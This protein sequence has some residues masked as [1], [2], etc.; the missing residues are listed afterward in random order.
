MVE[1]TQAVPIH[2]ENVPDIWGRSILAIGKRLKT[3]PGAGHQI[4]DSARR[5]DLTRSG[6]LGQTVSNMNRRAGHVGVADVYF[7]DLNANAHA[8]AIWSVQDRAGKAYGARGSVE[9]RIDALGAADDSALKAWEGLCRNGGER[10]WLHLVT[11]QMDDGGQDRLPLCGWNFLF[12]CH[13][14]L[15]DGGKEGILI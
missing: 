14:E 9:D 10:R 3:N 8:V 4:S 7:A 2:D 13:E 11:C 12:G 5:Q 15:L 1:L 6:S